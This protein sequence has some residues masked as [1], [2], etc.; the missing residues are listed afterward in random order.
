MYQLKA[1]KHYIYY[2]VK[3]FNGIRVCFETK[4]WYQIQITVLFDLNDGKAIA[5]AL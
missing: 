5:I 2:S 4:I 3:K 1:F